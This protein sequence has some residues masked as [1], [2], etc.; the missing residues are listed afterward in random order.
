[1]FAIFFIFLLNAVYLST[2]NYLEPGQIRKI[3]FQREASGYKKIFIKKD[4]N[5][6]VDIDAE[7][8]TKTEKLIKRLL[9]SK[10]DTFEPTD[11]EDQVRNG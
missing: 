8:K 4:S 1:M 6:K 2:E 10:T 11:F 7:V 9:T 5:H 3:Y